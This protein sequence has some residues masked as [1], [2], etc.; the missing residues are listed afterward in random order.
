MSLAEKT[1]LLMYNS[2][3]MV[4]T[5]AIEDIK[6][7]DILIASDGER[8]PVEAVETC[9]DELFT[10]TLSNGDEF[11]CNAW[12]DIDCVY[13]RAPNDVRTVPLYALIGKRPNEIFAHGVM[14]ALPELRAPVTWLQA[15]YT[16]GRDAPNEDGLTSIPDSI[17]NTD[18]NSRMEFL[19]GFAD[20]WGESSRYGIVFPMINVDD[21]W[22]LKFLCRSLGFEVTVLHMDNRYTY[23]YKVT[24]SGNL[25]SIP[26]MSCLINLD[27]YEPPQTTMFYGIKSI[28]SNGAGKNYTIRVKGKKSA[29][30]EDFT[31]IPIERVR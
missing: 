17:L 26:Y 5:S 29:I 7:G 16:I 4:Y 24:I 8:L 28:K 22:R 15:P 11:V 27:R 10:V 14:K 6:K 25:A 20:A 1:H 23:N 13:N 9:T 21:T 31:Q 30:L 12:Q 18:I 2:D 19:A 3:S